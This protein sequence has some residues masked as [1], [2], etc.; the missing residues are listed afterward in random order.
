MNFRGRKNIAESYAQRKFER[1]AGL[2][3]E[4]EAEDPSEGG[5]MDGRRLEPGEE[6]ER[7]VQEERRRGEAKAEPALAVEE[8]APGW[9]CFSKYV[10]AAVV[11][12]P[13]GSGRELGRAKRAEGFSDQTHPGHHPFPLSEHQSL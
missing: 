2:E 12:S 4:L 10:A 6:E 11:G 3:K 5:E 8:V 1:E 9:R 7:L 13:G